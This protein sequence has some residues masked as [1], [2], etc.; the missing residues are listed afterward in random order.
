M[1]VQRSNTPQQFRLLCELAKWIEGDQSEINETRIHQPAWI[2]FFL[3]LH[4]P[5]N[6]RQTGEPKPHETL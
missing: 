1:L 3:E 2:L 5:D 6:V 4:V